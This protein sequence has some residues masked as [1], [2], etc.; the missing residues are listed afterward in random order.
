[1]RRML[2]MLCALTM[3]TTACGSGDETAATDATTA[4]DTTAGGSVDTDQPAVTTHEAGSDNDDDAGSN[5]GG[6]G[7]RGLP[8]GGTGTV[9][10]N[11]EVI[12]SEWVGNCEIDEMFDPQPGDLDLT[13]SL[14]GGLDALFLEIGT[15]SIAMGAEPYEY[16]QFRPS[17]QLRDESGSYSSAET[18]FVTGPEGEWYEDGDG[19][20]AFTLARDAEPEKEPIPEPPLVLEDGR[21]RGAFTMESEGG[22]PIDVSFDLEYVDAVDCSL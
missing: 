3:V 2:M 7:A 18:I 22:D 10:I 21:A 15:L 19:L 11:G 6:N 12:D 8:P 4:T 20:V 1:M 13:A 14:G 5:D 17:L 9:T 16:L